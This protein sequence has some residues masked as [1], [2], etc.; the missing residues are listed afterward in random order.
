VCQFLVWLHY[1]GRA[2]VK[3]AIPNGVRGA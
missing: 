1:D 2:Q 3:I